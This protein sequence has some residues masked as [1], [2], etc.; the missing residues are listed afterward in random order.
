MD[1]FQLR[2]RVVLDDYARYVQSFVTIRDADIR[3]RVEAELH[4]GRLWPE[5]LVQ[6]NPAFASGGS[7]D[8]LVEEGLLHPAARAIFARKAEDGRRLASLQLFRHQVEAIRTARSGRSFVLTSGT[9]SGKSLSYIAPIVDDVLRAPTPGRVRAIVVYPMNALANSQEEELKKFLDRG[10]A[11]RPVTFARYTGQEKESA[12]KKA[13]TSPPDILL[14]NFAMLELILTRPAEHPIVRAAEGLR[15]LVLD[16]LHTYRGRQGADVALLIR[17]VREACRARDLRFIGTS[18]TMATGGTWD[19]QRLE[20]SRVASTLFGIRSEDLEVIG[21]TLE[22]A[23]P[24]SHGESRDQLRAEVERIGR[25]EAVPTSRADFLGTALASWIER[26]LGIAEEEGS[27]R[28]V[29]RK[30][31]ALGGDDGVARELAQ[32]TGLDDALCRD[33][34]QRMLLVGGSIEDIPG[35]RLFAFRLHQ[36]VAKGETV[37]ATLD[38][39]GAARHLTLDAQSLSPDRLRALYGLAFCRVCG[40]EYYLVRREAADGRDRFLQREL[41]DLR[42]EA[43]QEAGFLYVTDDEPWPEAKDEVFDRLPEDWVEEKNNRRVVRRDALPRVPQ[44]L[45]VGADG[46]VSVDG[47]ACTWL[48]A[49]MRFCLRCGIEYDATQQGDFGKLSTLATEGRSTAT[50]VL[51]LSTL[52]AL[53]ADQAM[54]LEAR[55]LLSFTDNRQDASLQAGHFNDFVMVTRLRTAIFRAVNEQA[56]GLRFEQLRQ[57]VFDALA[58]RPHEYAQRAEGE[59]T[60]E[61]VEDAALALRE[62]LGY[63]LLQ[64]LR[65]GWRVV[66]PNL[67]QCGLLRIR[68][69]GLDALC[70]IDSHWTDAPPSLRDATA[71]TRHA[72]CEAL[73]DHFR[74]ELSLDADALSRRKQEDI[75]SFADRELLPLWCPGDVRLMQ[76]ATTI[77]PRA[78]A[79]GAR[80]TRETPL[81]YLSERSGFA[82][83]LRRS[84][85]FPRLPARLSRDE[86]AA[87]IKS[88]LEV[89]ESRRF[90]RKSLE[91]RG[92][93]DVP[94]YQLALSKLR[95]HADVGKRGA[96]DL[97]R[98]RRVPD[99]GIP[100]NGF[101]VALYQG[102]AGTVPP[103]E[104]REH[105]AQVGADERERR[106]ERFR[107][108]SAP[109]GLPL[110]FCSP[111]MELG[112]DIA[113][114]NVVGLRNV[115]PT[116]AN[117]AQRSG[118]AGRSGQAAFVYTYCATGSAHDQYFFRRPTEMVSGAVRPPRLD[119]NNADLL[120]AHVHAIW[121]SVSG[122]ALGTSMRELL[123]VTEGESL[124]LGVLSSVRST[125]EDPALHRVARDAALRSL[126][127][128]LRDARAELGAEPEAWVERV[129][130]G[131]PVSFDDAC[132]RWRSMYRAVS[133]QYRR[134]ERR[135]S[136]ASRTL[137]E[138]EAARLLRAEAERQKEQLLASGEGDKADFYPYR[139]LASEA[140]LPGYNFP[141]LPLTAFV[142]ANG[143]RRAQR[144]TDSVQRPRF[145]AIS[146]FGPRS[147]LYHEGSRYV[148]HRV[149]RAVDLDGALDTRSAARCERCGYLHPLRHH[150]VERCEHCDALL[151]AKMTN[152]FHMRNVLTR[153]R[154]RISSDEEERMR[155]GYRIET[156]VRFADRGDGAAVRS[157][158][159]DSE[160]GAVRLEYSQAATL[161]RMNLGWRNARRDALPGFDLDLDKNEWRT[162]SGDD[163]DDDDDAIRSPVKRVVPFVEDHRNALLVTPAAT[164]TLGQ[165]ASLQ[166]ALKIAIQAEYQLEDAELAAEPLPTAQDR[167]IVLLYEA[168]E[169]GAG[170]LRRLVEDQHA[171]AK[172]CRRALE[173]CHFDPRTGEDLDD[174][175]QRGRRDRCASACYDCL[176]SYSNQ[177]D[178]HHLDRF[179]VRDLLLAWAAEQTRLSPDGRDRAEVVAA[180]ARLAGSALETRWLRWVEAQG[181]RVPDDAQR[182]IEGASCVADFW[183]DDNAIAVFIDGPPHDTDAQRAHDAEVDEKLFHLGITPL[184]FHHAED[185]AVK[186]KAHAFIFGSG[187]RS[188]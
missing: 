123:D 108:G 143:G 145:L 77:V 71:E 72:V 162:K 103:I 106:E 110:L 178:H 95:W 13:Q 76:H 127:E 12:R 144:R 54:D 102:E 109:G 70:A 132:G 112:V 154:S 173:L 111:T 159:I 61:V 130:A 98:I 44:N 187:G 151:S 99:E 140:W 7:V 25:G 117:Y 174:R 49:P 181:Y 20:I 183:Y 6:L 33:A 160:Q 53:A 104:A 5:A 93:D 180:H 43:G 65:S 29:R 68:Y 37:F 92:K 51:A 107:K 59:F 88:L 182:R 86:A 171:F 3:R 22:R 90:L 142:E 87:T 10:F 89:L 83:F 64:D 166:A 121:L 131:L 168:S 125:L 32:A 79:Q 34:L 16:E 179:S 169:G 46:T 120:R 75:V 19:D 155:L 158:T 67:E 176:R 136:D 175:V 139:Y 126:D 41:R 40:Q 82:R 52:S 113:Q 122:L 47:V 161:W 141:R 119:L 148:I 8:S 9:G 39:P 124:A 74:R 23:T 55:K 177:P 30:P 85:T 60:A 96:V 36:F 101:F 134:Q 105:T 80:G 184:R 156:A 133:E 4:A 58:L 115:P 42:L 172:V 147:I 163:D 69:E 152:L 188:R 138:R 170:V 17:R 137:Q 63:L 150:D 2:Q 1:V 81:R 56:E 129:L 157:A 91:S 149:M 186:A 167:R 94:G 116:P 164:L 38:P 73:L 26:T 100:T 57:R 146:E 185:W 135:A 11:E 14:T 62:V 27:G 24:D 28:L 31:R 97:T 114:L 15:F 84:Q 153:R 78:R 18:A 48:P 66:A 50:T 128:V 45:R 21:E 118:R 35:R 165:M